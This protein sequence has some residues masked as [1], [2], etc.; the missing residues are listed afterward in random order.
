MVCKGW[1]IDHRRC[2]L[3]SRVMSSSTIL[4]C[5]GTRPALLP[6]EMHRAPVSVIEF[7]PTVGSGERMCSGSMAYSYSSATLQKINKSEVIKKQSISMQKACWL[8]STI[9]TLC[10]VVY[11]RKSTNCTVKRRSEE[12]SLILQSTALHARLLTMD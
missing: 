5:L 4:F 6:E 2:S 1:Y 10:P 9:M 12:V 3:T 7:G 11:R 8:D